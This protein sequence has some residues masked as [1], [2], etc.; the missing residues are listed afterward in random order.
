MT[1]FRK[2]IDERIR[3]KRP[4][5]GASSV[6]TYVSILSN[7]PKNLKASNEDL[8]WFDKEEKEIMDFLKEKPS[9]TRKSVLSALFVLTGNEAYR[10][11]MLKDCGVVNAQYKEQKKSTKET[12]NWISTEQIQEIYEGLLDKVSAMFK[13]NLVGDYPTIMQFWFVALLGVF[14][15]GVRSIMVL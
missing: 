1:E 14:R 7:L 4:N 15:Q 10:D 3:E 2:N 5:L 9:Q 13:R 8:D 6:K 12:E 11:L